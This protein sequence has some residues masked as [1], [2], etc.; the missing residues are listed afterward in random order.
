MSG[1]IASLIFCRSEKFRE[2]ISD[3]NECHEQ[4]IDFPI[5]PSGQ[6]V[7]LRLF[8]FCEPKLLMEFFIVTFKLK[9]SS[10]LKKTSTC[11]S[12]SHFS[13]HEGRGCLHHVVNSCPVQTG[14]TFALLSA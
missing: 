11:F 4:I 6:E 1:N 13:S 5:L 3:I 10:I 7:K 2:T 14:H 8:Y 12:C 9:Q